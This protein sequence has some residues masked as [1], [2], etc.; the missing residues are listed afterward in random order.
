LRDAMP[1]R[2]R[3]SASIRVNAHGRFSPQLVSRAAAGMALV[4]VLLAA[5]PRAQAA[6]P[7]ADRSG[8]TTQL[9]LPSRGR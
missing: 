2:Q 6:S 8:A 7:E 5:G 9:L 4:V 3:P 1:L